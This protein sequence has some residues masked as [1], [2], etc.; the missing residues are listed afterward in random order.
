M[1][2]DLIAAEFLQYTHLH[3]IIYQNFCNQIQCGVLNPGQKLVISPSF[4][5]HST[6]NGPMVEMSLERLTQSPHNLPPALE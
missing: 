1:I 4:S 5:V 6:S 3:M 2:L